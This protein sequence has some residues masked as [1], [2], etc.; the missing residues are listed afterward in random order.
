[1]SAG[2]EYCRAESSDRTTECG[3][4][5]IGNHPRPAAPVGFIV[6]REPFRPMFH[7]RN[8]ARPESPIGWRAASTTRAMNLLAQVGFLRHTV[9]FK[10]DAMTSRAIWSR[11][12]QLRSGVIARPSGSIFLHTNG[13]E[14]RTRRHAR[15]RKDLDTMI[16]CWHASEDVTQAGG[17]GMPRKALVCEHSRAYA[18]QSPT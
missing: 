5:V 2:I 8:H 14:S 4:Q 11:V 10:P 18:D 17:N 12:R 9:L 6:A 13:T 3:L 1:M 15:R 7:R 16:P